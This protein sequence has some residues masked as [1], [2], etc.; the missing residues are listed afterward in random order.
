MKVIIT[1][2]IPEINVNQEAPPVVTTTQEV[3][4]ITPE[5]A[6]SD[7]RPLE[8]FEPDFNKPI[9]AIVNDGKGNKHRVDGVDLTPIETSNVLD[10]PEENKEL[11]DKE[12]LK[13][14]RKKK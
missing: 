7:E 10:E 1:V 3:E 2:E 5:T 4:T 9:V 6:V 8:D 11:E 14:K 12:L 13:P